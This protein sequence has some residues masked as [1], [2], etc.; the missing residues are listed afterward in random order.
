MKRNMLFGLAALAAVTAA[1]CA[2]AH[3][4]WF[5]PRL[6]KTQLVLGEGPKDNAYD[7]KAV[8]ML[9]GYDAEWGKVAVEPVNGGD[10][11]TIAPAEN[12]AVVAVE[13]DY[14]YWSNGKDGKW[15]NAPMDQV[16]GSTVGTHA[17]KYGVSYFKSVKAVKPVEGLPFQIVPMTDPTTLKVGDPLVVQLLHDGKP[18]PDTNIIPDVVNH[19]TV[20]AKTD[21]EGKAALKVANG[22]VNV[23]GVELTYNY[24]KPTAKATRDKVFA[25]LSFVTVPPEED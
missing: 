19:H 23:I 17:V 8:T 21:D 14:G 6:D 2:N 16:E 9:Q 5:A 7:P 3:G 1:G 22:G 20:F 12:V 11:I 15:H 18:M 4:V 25:S 10:H 24:D 13:F